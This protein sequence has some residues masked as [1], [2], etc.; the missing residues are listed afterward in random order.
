MMSPFPSQENGVINDV[1]FSVLIWDLF[2]RSTILDAALVS[3][4]RQIDN[5][6]RRRF[7]ADVPE[8]PF[9]EAVRNVPDLKI[10]P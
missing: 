3:S 1:P 6:A 9:N 8:F 2:P 10:V 5:K 4:S 7:T